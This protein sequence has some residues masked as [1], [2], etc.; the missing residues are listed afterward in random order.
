MIT[1]YLAKK[2]KRFSS[3]TTTE[4]DLHESTG[5]SLSASVAVSLKVLIRATQRSLI[6]LRTSS[7]KLGK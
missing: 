1:I 2:W 3:I 7:A 4:C 5:H 6:D